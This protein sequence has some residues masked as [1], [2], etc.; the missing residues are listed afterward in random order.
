MAKKKKELSTMSKL[1]TR[2]WKVTTFQ[3]TTVPTA[4]QNTVRGSLHASHTATILHSLHLQTLQRWCLTIWRHLPTFSTVAYYLQYFHT[5]C[6]LSSLTH[7]VFYHY[8]SA[9]ASQRQQVPCY[10]R[11]WI[12]FYIPSIGNG[13]NPKNNK[14]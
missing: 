8:I 9:A 11:N 12:L 6:R 10:F 4:P 5:T 3:S 14:P 1:N 2:D 13:R 7:I